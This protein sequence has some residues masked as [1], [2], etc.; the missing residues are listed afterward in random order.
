MIPGQDQRGEALRLL[1]VDDSDSIRRELRAALEPLNL[2]IFEAANGRDALDLATNTDFAVIITDIEM[3]PINGFALLSRLERLHRDRRRPKV[4]V[5]S[6]L[7]NSR[8]LDDTAR[9]NE[10]FAL[11]A[12]PIV[13]TLL[14][15]TVAEALSASAHT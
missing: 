5:C 8:T 4:I 11:V 15:A 2:E 13:P 14:L 3:A 10:V 1:I 9:E 6:A 7:V 12:K